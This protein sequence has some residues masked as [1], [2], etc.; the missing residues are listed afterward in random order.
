MRILL[1]AALMQLDDCKNTKKNM[2]RKIKRTLKPD[3]NE[4]K[5]GNEH[6][7]EIL[8]RIVTMYEQQSRVCK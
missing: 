5:Y 8:M 3:D 7:R 2:H 1:F 6:S 4:M